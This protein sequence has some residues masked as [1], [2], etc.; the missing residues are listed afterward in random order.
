MPA[1]TASAPASAAPVGPAVETDLVGPDPSSPGLV[2]G[3]AALV[4]V[5]AGAT[6]LGSRRRDIES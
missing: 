6:L 4:F 5:G 3:G 2:G 1:D